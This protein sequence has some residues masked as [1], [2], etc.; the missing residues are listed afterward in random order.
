MCYYTAQ[1]IST[2]ACSVFDT[3]DSSFLG[4]FRIVDSQDSPFI[5]GT[6][7]TDGI[8]VTSF[9]LP[10]FDDELLVVQDDVNTSVS[11]NGTTIKNQNFKFVS[12]RE[13]RR[14][15]GL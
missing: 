15:L 8:A 7:E 1:V 4:A 11:S 12:W 14:S 13:I 6:S 2:E 3:A 9:S 10:G 5:D